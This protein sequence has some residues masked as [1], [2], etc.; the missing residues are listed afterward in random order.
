MILIGKNKAN[1]EATLEKSDKITMPRTSTGE[2][3]KT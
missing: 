3:R 2:E 1:N